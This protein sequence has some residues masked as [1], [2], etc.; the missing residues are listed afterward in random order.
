MKPGRASLVLLVCLLLHVALSTIISSP[1]WVPDLTLVGLMLA[2]FASPRAWLWYAAVA[3]LAT[4]VWAVRFP[5][6]IVMSYLIVGMIA[7]LLTRQWD[8]TDVRV[9]SL[10]VSAGSLLMT[11]GLLWLDNRISFRLAGLVMI[12][13]VMTGFS[14]L[15]IRRFFPWHT[16]RPTRPGVI[17]TRGAAP[18]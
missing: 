13:V 4:M 8:A 12:H 1:W 9:Q 3:G 17:P 15:I 5:L 11:A 2:I 16:R 6:P 14:A 10:V 7:Q 18:A